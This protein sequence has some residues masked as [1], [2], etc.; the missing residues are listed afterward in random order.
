[1]HVAGDRI[2]KDGLDMKEEIE[3]SP[4]IVAGHVLIEGAQARVGGG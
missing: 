4:Q 1:M 3:S 2:L